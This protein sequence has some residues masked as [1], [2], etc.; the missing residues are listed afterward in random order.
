MHRRFHRLA[1]MAQ[2]G[3]GYLNEK[4]RGRDYARVHL[5]EEIQ[6]LRN[7]VFCP[8]ISKCKAYVAVLC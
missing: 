2:L 5:H 3:W 7:D 1:S 6:S 8:A 4:T